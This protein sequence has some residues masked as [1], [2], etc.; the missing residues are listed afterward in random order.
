MTL[1]PRIRSGVAIGVLTL[2][3][4]AVGVVMRA[5][6][7]HDGNSS[8]APVVSAEPDAEQLRQICGSPPAAEGSFFCIGRD[9][10][11]SPSQLVIPGHPDRETAGVL[12]SSG[13]DR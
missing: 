9:R 13:R 1:T 2:A 5:A 6:A 3:A 10:S 11:I 12:Q 7:V 8:P 4:V